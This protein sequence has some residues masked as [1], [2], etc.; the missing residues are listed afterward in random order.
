[1]GEEYRRGWHPERIAPATSEAAVLIVGGGPAGLEA[2]LSLGRR[3][4]Q[5][6]L[7]EALDE[8]GGRVLLESALPGLGTWKRVVDYRLSQLHKLANVQLFMQSELDRDQILEFAGELGTAHMVV[9]TGSKWDRD[10]IGRAH[11][12]PVE[13]DGSVTVLTPDA[14]M[15][16]ESGAGTV[17]VYDDDHYYMGS[18]IAEKLADDGRHVT[19]VTP[20]ADVSV[21]SHNTLEQL[22][23]EKRLRDIGVRIVE[24]HRLE[25]L[26]QGK[27]R[28]TQVVSGE[29]TE[30]DCQTLVMVTA[31]QPT[32]HLYHELTKN[33]ESLEKA[34]IKTVTRI[35]DCLAPGTIAA[36]VYSGH[37]Y[38]R[39]F[40]E[41]IDSDG[42]PFLRERVAI[43]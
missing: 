30:F 37:R 3:G 1:M 5:V 31:R 16:G 8:P 29:L 12:S 43:E 38:A 22:H 17:T 10:G 4:Y 15:A 11:R 40:D 18:V 13:T 36:A 14:V 32:E 20:A 33:R 34:G 9:A 25:A 41:N 26:S 39:E 6:T 2:A 19:L 7:A 23:I 42:V 35:G 27:I 24:K 21:W 28:A